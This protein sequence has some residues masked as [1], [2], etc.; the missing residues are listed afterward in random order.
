MTD[1]IIYRVQDRTQSTISTHR[2]EAA[3]IKAASKIE[4]SRIVMDV[5]S[6]TYQSSTVIYP[7]VGTT[8]SR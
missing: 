8:Y 3:A 1:K 2:T 6:G 5:T 7:A 4:D